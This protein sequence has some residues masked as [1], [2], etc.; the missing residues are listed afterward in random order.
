MERNIRYEA[1]RE[2]EEECEDLTVNTR[3]Q[4]GQDVTVNTRYQRGQ[5]PT[6]NTRYYVLEEDT[7]YQAVQQEQETANTRYHVL[8][9]EDT[10]LPLTSQ[11]V[12]NAVVPIPTMPSV[13]PP[14]YRE[15][16]DEG[17]MATAESRQQQQP[18]NNSHEHK[19]DQTT[20]AEGCG[21][22]LPPSYAVATDLPSYEE[23]ERLKQEEELN[24]GRNINSAGHFAQFR[25]LTDDEHYLNGSDDANEQLNNADRLNTSGMTI[26]TDWIFFCTFVI[27]FL[28]NWLGFLMSLC[29]TNTVAGRCGALAGLGLSMVKWVAIV[30]HSGFAGDF[31]ASE[32]WFWWI[33]ML[34]GFLLFVRGCMQYVNVKYEW[35]RITGR[36]HHITLY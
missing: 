8:Q 2:E 20:F 33:L 6:V 31:A 4:G 25:S 26:G 28:F 12:P 3:C 9:E 13:P 19:S 15:T 22:G 32:S 35:K 36:L 16:E 17:G 34:C 23:A 14:A 11:S 24:G 27:S 5:D 7:R 30:K 21:A 10:P 29:I 1:L 18:L